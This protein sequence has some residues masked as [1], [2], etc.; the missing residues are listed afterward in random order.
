VTAPAPTW[1]FEQHRLDNGL[2]V[3]VSEDSSVP[4]A[5]VN[6]WYDVGSCHE[7]PGRTGFAHLF[8]HLMFEGSAHVAKGEHFALVNAAGGTLN[9]T[10]WCDRTNY[11]ETLPSNHLETA[12]WLEADRM[13]GLALDQE[14]LD[15]QR[16]VVKNERRQRV[17]NQPYGVWS[18]RIHELAYPEGHPYH[19]STIGSMEHLDAATLED[20]QRFYRTHYAPNNAVLTVVG[21]VSAGRV[22]ELAQRYFGGIPA[23]D[24][25]PPAPD[26]S[27]PARIGHEVRETLHDRVPAPRVFVAYRCP[28]FGTDEYDAAV[29]LG[30][31]LGDGRG[32]R[33][34]RRLILERE[35]A[36]Q[37]EGSFLDTW[38]FVGG[39][40]LLVGDATAREGVDISDLEGA[41]HDVVGSLASEPVTGE[42]L[43]RARALV[44]SAVL[45]RMSTLDGRADTF[46][47]YAT[48]FG[49]P[50]LVNEALPR[51]LAVSTDRLAQ[52]ADDVFRED[53]RVV[54]T[55]LPEEG[56]A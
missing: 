56:A 51:L 31:V 47:Q 9:A 40:A 49:D 21:D 14:T 36:Q 24:D 30:A 34:Y 16:A 4:A 10:T 33:L 12:L 54:L 26:S 27:L 25:I 39:A 35:L 17:D 52:L 13:G 28:P 53:N 43:E 37:P 29:M 32:C 18:D 42:E 23:R 50:S 20:A 38:G 22:V 7:E 8:E 45:H 55:F 19:H 1:P 2:R 48:L 6:L 44:T 3:I 5:A 11:F 15:N 46:S 41:Y